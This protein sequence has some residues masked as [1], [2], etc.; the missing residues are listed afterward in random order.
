[1]RASLGA[2]L[3]RLE[4]AAANLATITENTEIARSTLLDLDVASEMSRF[5]QASLRS[6]VVATMMSQAFG[7]KRNLLQIIDQSAHSPNPK[8][9][10]PSNL[11]HLKANL[12]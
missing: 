1:M 12:E 3:N 6:D 8:Q 10:Q 9:N 4:F 5:I 11:R 7:L 2:G